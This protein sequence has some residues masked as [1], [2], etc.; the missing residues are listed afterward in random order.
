MRSF[1]ALP[2]RKRVSPTRKMWPSLIAVGPESLRAAWNS[3]MKVPLLLFRSSSIQDEPFQKI[4]AWRRDRSGSSDI[5]SSEGAARPIETVGGIFRTKPMP[6]REYPSVG[7][8][9][10]SIPKTAYVG[11]PTE[12]GAVIERKA[13]PAREIKHSVRD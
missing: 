6:V 12:T 11:V 10:F 8:C 1:L 5:T 13:R 4:R 2:N 9:L 7:F 3:P